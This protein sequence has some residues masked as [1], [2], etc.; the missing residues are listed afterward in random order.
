[1]RLSQLIA[2]AT[3]VAVGSG[4]PGPNNTLLLASGMTFGFRRTAPHVVGT[5]VGIVLL[6]GIAGAG[7]GVV[8]AAV[9]AVKV[10]L[11]VVASAYLIYLAARLAGGVA[12]DRAAVQNPF[13]V[14]RATAFQF[15]NPKGWV[16]AFALV[17]AFAPASGAGII[18]GITAVA[19]VVAATAALWALGGT[20]LS[21]ALEGDRARR[22]TGVALGVLLLASVA[23][24]WV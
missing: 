10:V 13:S 7:A 12:L 23:F 4:S 9:P 1:M 20:T 24:L 3:F 6:V 11:K 14:A 2:L 16:F 18:L 5:S 17:G 21:R 8:I 19:V 15:V 22:V